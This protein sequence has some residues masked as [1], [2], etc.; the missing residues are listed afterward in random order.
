M[1]RR[2]CAGS[3]LLASCTSTPVTPHRKWDGG[4]DNTR[5]SS[6]VALQ[7]PVLLATPATGN[8]TQHDR[9]LAESGQP[10]AESSSALRLSSFALTARRC[11][12]FSRANQPTLGGLVSG[13]NSTWDTPSIAAVRGAA[14]A[15]PRGPAITARKSCTVRVSAGGSLTI[16]R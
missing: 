10:K 13:G 15:T 9:R 8:Q 16:V 11:R 6:S 5:A 12:L 4:S 14:R 7:N 2:E 1:P 3:H